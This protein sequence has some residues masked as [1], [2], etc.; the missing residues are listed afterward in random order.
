MR[1]ENKVAVVTGAAQ[2]IGFACAE[3]FAREGAKVILSDIDTTKGEEAAERLQAA[4]GEALFVPCDVGDKGQVDSLIESAVFAYGRLDCLIANAGIVHTSS[5]LDLAE[6]DF[7]RVIRVN[8]KGVFLSG[9]AA[10]RQM[11]GQDPDERGC[12]GTIINMSSV[13]AVMAIP[14]ITPYVVAKGGVN[15]LTKVMALNLASHGIRVNAIG[16][17]SIATEMFTAVASDRDKL[18]AVLSRTPMGR[19]GEPDEI[20]SV[21]L[22][23]ATADSSYITGQTIYPDG[24]RLGLNYTVPVDED[25]L[26]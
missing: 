9:Q 3:R 26:G 4:G 20:A 14:A 21:A 2:G 5:F 18:R 11:V 13:N 22:F 19:P 6:A 16:P 15:Q 10:A 1:L 7:D 23:L 25:A 17:G 24:G 8:L 12:R